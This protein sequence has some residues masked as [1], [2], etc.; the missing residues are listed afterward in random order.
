MKCKFCDKE[1][2]PN[3]RGYCQSCYKYFIL[4]RKSV[5]DLP[6]IGKVEYTEGGDPICHI[7]GMAYRKL[8]NHIYQIH[9]MT[10]YDYT[11][12]FKLNHRRNNLTNLDYRLHM[13]NIQKDYCVT[14]NLIEKGKPTRIK[15]GDQLRKKKEK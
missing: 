15:D 4:D 9:H 10:V 5:Y 2:V 6:E 7:C 8:G 14:E 11:T 12:K 3:H 13:K 1:A